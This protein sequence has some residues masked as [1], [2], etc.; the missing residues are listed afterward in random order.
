MIFSELYSAY[1]NAVAK[2]IRELINGEKNE[3]RLSE[4]VS[5]KAFGESMLT[6]LPSLK[7]EKWQ[8][9]KSNMTTPIKHSPT[10]PLTNIEK[11][12]L[13][14]V[15]MDPRIRL[16]GNY[17][18]LFPDTKPLFTPDDYVIYDRYSDGDDFTDEGYIERFRTILSAVKSKTPLDIRM[19]NRKGDEIS[20]TIL[21][22]RLE[23][24]EKDD[25]MRLIGI[26]KGNYDTINLARIISCK[27]SK[28]KDFSFSK[29]EESKSRMVTLR[30]TD[31]R[32]ALERCLLHFAHFEKRA[33][34]IDDMNYMVHIVYDKDDETE[35]VIRIL[36]F[37]PLVEVTEPQHFREL[38]IERLKRQAE[39]NL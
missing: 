3:N 5:E 2:I 32:N 37:G 38:I 17:D 6:V 16:F 21:P 39:F 34:K 23:Y 36:S 19:L 22:E 25:K 11:S 27:E 12:W 24:S 1:Y 15:F 14:A 13:K 29:K 26:G 9:M 28:E 7:S 30:I 4:I 33:E 31:R 20:V 10:M 35:L 18:N 8:L